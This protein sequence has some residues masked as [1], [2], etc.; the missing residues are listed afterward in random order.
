MLKVKDYEVV[1]V[2]DT[3]YVVV[4]LTDG[5]H[6][7]VFGLELWEFLNSRQLLDTLYNWA[8]RIFRARKLAREVVESGDF[9]IVDRIMDILRSVDLDTV[10]KEELISLLDEV[11][12]C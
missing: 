11:V 7:E 9:S 2:D 4:T 3:A 10:K 12:K 8:E 6:D 5:E 1:K